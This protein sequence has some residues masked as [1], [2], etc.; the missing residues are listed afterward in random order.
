L[1]AETEKNGNNNNNSNNNN[2]KGSRDEERGSDGR[3]MSPIS[4]AFNERPLK[5][6]LL[7]C[8]LR[9][10]LTAFVLAIPYQNDYGT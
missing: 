3:P 5:V 9:P 6:S 1:A 2:E 10:C 8:K 7:L 4:S